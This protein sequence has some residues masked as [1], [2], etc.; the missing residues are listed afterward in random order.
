MRQYFSQ[1]LIW[2][3]VIEATSL[4][5]RAINTGF[6]MHQLQ[7]VMPTVVNNVVSLDLL[8]NCLS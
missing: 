5:S 8:M 6:I 3:V 1:L 7:H 2:F 4:S